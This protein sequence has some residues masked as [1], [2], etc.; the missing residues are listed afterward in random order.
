[1]KMN[2]KI[3]AFDPEIKDGKEDKPHFIWYCFA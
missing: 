3:L 1:M 2:N